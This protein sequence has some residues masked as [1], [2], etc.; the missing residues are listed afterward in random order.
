MDLQLTGKTALVTGGSEGIGKGITLA[1][2]K[3]GVDVAICARRKD[4]L[5]A[6]AAEIAR[7]TNRKIVAIPADLRKDADAKNFIEQAHKALGRVDIMINKAGSAAGGVIEHLT[8]DDWEKGLQLKFMGYVRC[9]R[10]VLP[11]MVKQGGGRVVNLIGNDGVKP[12][13]WEI[14]PGAANAAGQNLTL[15]LAGQYGKSN[16]SFCA[17]NP[18][19]VRTERWVG[20]VKAMSRDMNLSYEEADKL[21]PSS[22]PM[23]R[24]AEVE[25]V[26]NLVVMLASPLMHMVNGTMIEV[27]GGQEKS[28]M[29]R[30]RDK[31]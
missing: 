12:S 16:I 13:Y 25:E 9:L 6:T 4:V 15:S 10:Y 19:P 11:I 31:K 17:V 7:A 22:I 30:L 24:I 29:D 14:C 27:D 3:E 1:L 20:L 2:A 5:E 28:L 21:A 8:E 26:A 23:G 18:G